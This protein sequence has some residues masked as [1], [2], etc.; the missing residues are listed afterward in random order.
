MIMNE[1]PDEIYLLG[2]DHNWIR[3]VGQ[4]RHFYDS[5]ESIV[6]SMGYDE[7]QG[8]D[9]EEATEREKQCNDNLFRIYEQYYN[10]AKQHN[11]AIYN[12]TPGS[13]LEVFP[14]T[15]LFDIFEEPTMEIV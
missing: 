8:Q 7:W 13:R 2:C 3:H 14:K 1:R 5:S 12:V 4:T 9:K 10:L 11:I 6:E 15:T